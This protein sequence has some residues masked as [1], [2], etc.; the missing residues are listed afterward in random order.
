[1]SSS[2]SSTLFEE[3]FESRQNDLT[4]DPAIHLAYQAPK[5]RLSMVD[6]NLSQNK[7]PVS[8]KMNFNKFKLS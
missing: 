3:S 8:G 7:A 5:E 6:L 4:F 1:M 2:S